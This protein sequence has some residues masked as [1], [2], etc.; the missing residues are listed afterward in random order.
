[1]FRNTILLINFYHFSFACMKLFYIF[2]VYSKN[3]KTPLSVFGIEQYLVFVVYFK[4]Q[5]YDIM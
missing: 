5:S 2:A 4:H 1:M 3:V